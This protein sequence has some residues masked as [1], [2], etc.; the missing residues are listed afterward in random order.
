VL[1]R[2]EKA[3]FE[4]FAKAVADTRLSAADELLPQLPVTDDPIIRRLQ[5]WDRRAHA[6]SVETTWFVLAAESARDK[7]LIDV[8]PGVLDS[9]RATFGTIEVPWGA[10]NRIQRPLSGASVTL[11]T[12]RASLPVQGAPGGLGSVFTFNTEGLGE[13]RPRNGTSGNSFVKVIEFGPTPRATSILNYGQS[14]DPQSAHFFDQ[15]SLYWR[16]EF[17]P[18]WFTRA[19]VER[20]AVRKY[21]VKLR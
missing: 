17:K 6:N 21:E 14:G 15:A 16:G 4:D 18:A 5:Q 11:D 9:L 10:I 20:N 8:L 2:L 3:S 1:E 7:P 13:A 12:S 19:D